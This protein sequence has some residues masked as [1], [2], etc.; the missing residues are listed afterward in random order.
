M[1]TKAERDGGREDGRKRGRE[2]ER[3]GGRQDRKKEDG[4]RTEGQKL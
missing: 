4:Q 2:E 1:G 3:T